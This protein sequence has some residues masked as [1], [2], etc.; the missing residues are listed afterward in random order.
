MSSYRRADQLLPLAE[1]YRQ[2]VG[3]WC[4]DGTGNVVQ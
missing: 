3:R 1:N 4:A 2:R